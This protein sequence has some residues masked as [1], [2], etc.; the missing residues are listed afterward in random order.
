MF[1]A[2]TLYF[3]GILLSN[4]QDHQYHPIICG[5][6][7]IKRTVKKKKK[8]GGGFEKKIR[9]NPHLQRRYRTG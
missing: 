8:K 2:T 6:D 1:V 5:I 4:R 3:I 9:N 7:K